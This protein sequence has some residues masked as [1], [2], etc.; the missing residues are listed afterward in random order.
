[1]RKQLLRRCVFAAVAVGLAVTIPPPSPAAAVSPPPFVRT[2]G[3]YGGEDGKF[4]GPRGITVDG[5]YLYVA[6]D[7]NDRIQ[8]FTVGGAYVTKWG[9]THGSGDGAFIDPYDVAIG[10]VNDFAYVADKGNHRIQFF[11]SSG[12]YQNKWGAYPNPS[13]P[14]SLASD[15]NGNI[16]VVESGANRITEYG[17]YGVFI[18]QWGTQ[19]GGD[20]QFYVPYGI[21]I[22]KDGYVYVADNGNNRIQKFDS[23]GHF[24]TK[25]GSQGAGDGQFQN[26]RGVAVDANGHV[27]VADGL[28][29]RLQEFDT[30]GNFLTKWGSYGT[31]P[32][33]LFEP[34]DVAVDT[35]G[36]VYVSENKNNRISVFGSGGGGGGKSLIDARIA[37]GAGG[38]WLGD[39][40]FNRTGAAQTLSVTKK[41]GRVATFTVSV[42]NDGDKTD[43][44]AIRGGGSS[45][46]FSV[47]Y[48]HAG[49]DVSPEV[50]SGSLRT[51]DL[52]PGDT[53][54]ISVVVR[55]APNATIGSR[56]S[57]LVTVSSV[58]QPTKKDAVGF[59]VRAKR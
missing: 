36:N 20:G 52:A 44:A 1:M 14:A 50:M 8:K 37:A 39:E 59:I 53:F 55:V 38:V 5:G 4:N 31:E 16:Y 23:A 42:E 45:P 47:H 49:A 22:D 15:A 33:K 19:G 26:P 28:N 41:R 56:V 46:G 12:G 18:R 30:S 32:G 57:R 10:A 7:F 24:V 13:A 29:H 9:G 34:W 17:S 21:A 25:W 58:A 35:A 40:V 3:S 51:G 27:F 6:D 48:R 2:I 11:T 43:R 54:T